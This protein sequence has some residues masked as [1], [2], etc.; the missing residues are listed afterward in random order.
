M[1]YA[2]VETSAIIFC[3]SV[4]WTVL[5][6]AASI[7]TW[8]C[9]SLF[10]GVRTVGMTFYSGSSSTPQACR[11]CC[12]IHLDLNWWWLPCNCVICTWIGCQHHPNVRVGWASNT[13][14][15]NST[16]TRLWVPFWFQAR[17]KPIPYLIYIPHPLFS[18]GCT[19]C[20]NHM[21]KPFLLVVSTCLAEGKK[22]HDVG[23]R[24]CW[25]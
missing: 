25:S 10:A 22:C 24:T 6:G 17:H 5:P 9:T 14:S 21:G 4:G 7:T 13:T 11:W 12:F 16:L 2:V 20:Y 19:V 8:T 3:E 1:W 23:N 15:L 18:N